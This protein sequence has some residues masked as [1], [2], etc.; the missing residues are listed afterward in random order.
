M[1]FISVVP[2]FLGRRE[3]ELLLKSPVKTETLYSF[4]SQSEKER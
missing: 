1:T 3:K 4:N 2:F